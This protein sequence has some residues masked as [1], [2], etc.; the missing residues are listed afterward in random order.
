MLFSKKPKTIT[1]WQQ[2]QIREVAPLPPFKQEAKK[3]ARVSSI[4]MI[5]SFSVIRT[6]DWSFVATNLGTTIV[7][8]TALSAVVLFMRRNQGA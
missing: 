5:P 4:L 8:F 6:Q 3:I 7:F 2:R 1:D